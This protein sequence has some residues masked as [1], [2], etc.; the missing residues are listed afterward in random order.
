MPTD[1]P[2]QRRRFFLAGGALAL[3]APAIGCAFAPKTEAAA[4]PPIPPGE[5]RVWFYR[6][7]LPSET[8]NMT[9]VTMNGATVG[10]AQLGGAFY[11]DVPPGGYHIA[12]NSYGTDMSQT[13]DLALAPGQEAYIKIESLRSWASYGERNPIGRDTFY[14]RQVPVEIAR[15]GV[16]HATFYG[17]S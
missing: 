14:A 7:F 9:A 8:L 2:N 5:A 11:R 4:I 16:A 10:Y 15:A 17:G 3:L 13:T 12:A 6:D 1:R